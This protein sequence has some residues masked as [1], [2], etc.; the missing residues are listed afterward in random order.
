MACDVSAEEGFD[1]DP[2]ADPILGTPDSLKYEAAY[3]RALKSKKPLLVLVGSEGCPPCQVQKN[4]FAEM[5]RAGKL[6]DV[7]LALMDIGHPQASVVT[8]NG[9]GYPWLVGYVLG[10]DGK[11]AR[12]PRFGYQPDAKVRP[13]IDELKRLAL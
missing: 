2:V 12:R 5:K 3:A 11:W 1:A 7:E 10:R 8:D 6:E 13:L 9:Q 4:T